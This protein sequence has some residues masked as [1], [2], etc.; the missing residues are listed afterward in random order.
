M[1]ARTEIMR[2]NNEGKLEAAYQAANKGLV[3]PKTAQRQ[4]MTAPMDV[5][6]VCAP[7]HGVTVGLYESW[8]LG[9]PP[10]HPNCRCTF[11]LITNPQLYGVPTGTGSGLSSTYGG[12]ASFTFPKLPKLDDDFLPGAPVIEPLPPV[13]TQPAGPLPETLPPD[14]MPGSA[15]EGMDWWKGE[16]LN[17]ELPFEDL[18]SGLQYELSQMAKPGNV[19]DMQAIADKLHAH[20]VYSSTLVEKFP[21]IEPPWYKGIGYDQKVE[22]DDLPKWAKTKLHTSTN[23]KG[24]LD[25]DDYDAVAAIVDDLA[26]ATVADDILTG[27]GWLVQR[28]VTSRKR[29]Q[30]WKTSSA[31]SSTT[32]T[33]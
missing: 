11:R 10:A 21:T 31:R 28:P 1:I 33:P 26:P 5:C 30:T 2:A 19:D 13:G 29:C 27:S 18:P 14:P 20:Q 22:W 17:D 9:D 25:Y 15:P 12:R 16:K 3:D 6:Q 7:L 23:K 4:W 24:F 32:R 8:Y